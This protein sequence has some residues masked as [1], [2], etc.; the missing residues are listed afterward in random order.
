MRAVEQVIVAQIPLDPY[1]G[2]RA[3]AAYSGLS[4]PT[5]KRLLVADDPIPHF[6]PAKKILV[7]RSE[8]DAWMQRRRARATTDV[9]GIVNDVLRAV[10]SG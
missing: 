2:L 5:L 6:K 8:F 3:L 4:L 1:L 9:A 10:R 7:R